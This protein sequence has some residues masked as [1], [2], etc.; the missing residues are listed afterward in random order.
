MFCYFRVLHKYAV[1]SGR[2]GRAELWCGLGGN[3]LLVFAVMFLE[4]GL[5]LSLGEQPGALTGAVILALMPPWV[6]VCV[7]RLH[8]MG[9]DGWHIFHPVSNMQMPFLAGDSGENMYGPPPGS[10]GGGVK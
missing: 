6:A 1:F 5:G 10:D 4:A 2:A 3:I 7:R 9:L 8:D